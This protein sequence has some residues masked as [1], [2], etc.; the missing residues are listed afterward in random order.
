MRITNMSTLT[1]PA[2][3]LPATSSVS[4]MYGGGHQVS[5]PQAHT[6][7]PAKIYD[8]TTKL[9]DPSAKLYDSKLYDPTK[10]YENMASGNSAAAAY[11][12]MTW[13]TPFKYDHLATNWPSTAAANATNWYS[14]QAPGLNI[15]HI[16]KPELQDYTR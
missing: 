10:P 2:Q 12:C 4:T 9:Y 1:L 7:E 6:Y 14:H 15:G 11:T 5:L 8:S 3:Y 16:V 13:Q